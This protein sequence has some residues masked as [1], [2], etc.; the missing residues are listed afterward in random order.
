MT[1]SEQF[2]NRATMSGSGP[3]PAKFANVSKVPITGFQV[4]R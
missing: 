4:S 2:V 3:I 1:A